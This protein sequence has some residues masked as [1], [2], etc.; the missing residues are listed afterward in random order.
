MPYEAWQTSLYSSPG[1][2]SSYISPARL[3]RG[4]DQRGDHSIH[5]AGKVRTR[6]LVEVPVGL[7]SFCLSFSIVH[8]AL[9]HRRHEDALSEQHDKLGEAG[10][11]AGR[12]S[13]PRQL[14]QPE[15]LLP[16]TQG[17]LRLAT[18][19]MWP[20]VALLA[21]SC[22]VTSCAWEERLVPL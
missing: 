16:S 13:F 14:R 10:G 7:R 3:I 4:M 17:T 18:V 2:K 5:L 8:R 6:Y 19:H 1:R 21:A 9:Q 15:P 11:W 20:A 22:I 12:V